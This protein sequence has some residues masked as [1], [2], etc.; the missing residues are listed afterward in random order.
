MNALDRAFLQIREVDA[1]FAELIEQMYARRFT[2]YTG[3]D[4]LNGRPRCLY[5]PGAKVKLRQTPIDK[6]DQVPDAVTV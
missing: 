2:G 6:A 5:L 4:W 3:I 1:D